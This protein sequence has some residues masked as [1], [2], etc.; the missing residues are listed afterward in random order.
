[1]KAIDDGN[2]GWEIEVRRI[3]YRIGDRM[4]QLF[5]QAK[6]EWFRV[7]YG[8]EL[9]RLFERLLSGGGVNVTGDKRLVLSSGDLSITINRIKARKVTIRLVPKGLLGI[10]IRVP[11]YLVSICKEPRYWV[12]CLVM[13]VGMK[14]VQ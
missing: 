7:H 1:M 6:E 8:G 10:N 2:N 14:V 3:L 5:K 13:R 4:L 11:S 12:G 9:N